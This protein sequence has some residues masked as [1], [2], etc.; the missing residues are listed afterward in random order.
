MFETMPIVAFVATTMPDRAKEFYSNILGLQLLVAGAVLWIWGWE[1][2]KKISF[3]WF[4]LGFAWPYLFLEETLAFKLRF[5]MVRATSAFLNFIC[6]ATQQDT[7]SLDGLC[8][9]S[10]SQ[11]KI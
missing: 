5:L 9:I 7:Q 8:R 6:V 3:A 1:H 10:V 11:F 2:F 4:V